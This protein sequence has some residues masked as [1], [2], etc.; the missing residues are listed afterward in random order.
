MS[1]LSSA[2]DGVYLHTEFGRRRGHGQALVD[3]VQQCFDVI[4]VDVI[5]RFEALARLEH[6]SGQFAF[7]YPLGDRCYSDT[8]QCRGVRWSQVM[9]AHRQR[10]RLG[11]HCVNLRPP[12]RLTKVV[13]PSV[14][15]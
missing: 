14:Q 8:E 1:K 13:R 2:V 10:V 7:A 9:L 15:Y 5:A 12:L 3:F 11:Q 4:G 6:C